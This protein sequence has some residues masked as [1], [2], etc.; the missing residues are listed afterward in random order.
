[1]T[2]APLNHP[3]DE[4]LRALS[5][6]QLTEAELAHVSAHLG[7]CPACCRRIDQL[8][9]DDPLLARLQQERR[10]PGRMSWSARPS[11]A[12]RFAPCAGRTRPG[13]P[14]G[15]RP[16][17]RSGDSPRPRAGRG[18][19]HPGR[20]RARGHGGGVQG[21]APGPAPAGRPEDG[22]GGRVRVPHPGAAVPAGGGAGGAGAAPQHRA[23]LRDRQLRR[24]AFPGPGVGR[25]RQSGEPAGWQA[26]AAG[27]GGRAHRDPG[28]CHRRGPRRRRRP[29]GPEAGNVLLALDPGA[30]GR[31]SLLSLQWRP[32][33]DTRS[34]R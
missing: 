34:L 6:G 24:P 31:S 4:A 26:L 5:L 27:R 11:V 14:R 22:A 20:G 7:D 33:R 28:P 12:R 19:R 2:E 9:T 15:T 25:G 13:R 8:A 17:S 1:M 3:G 32:E 21:A 29:P 18:L 10:Q 23:G 16:G 30:R